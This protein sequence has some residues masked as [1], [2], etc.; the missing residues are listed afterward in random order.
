MGP[1]QPRGWHSLGYLPHFDSPETIQF[2]TF[3]L[4][5]SLPASATESI[6]LRDHI[7]Q[8]LDRE[9][10]VGLGACWLKR[11]DIASLVEKAL[12]HFDGERYRL[13]AW[14]LM[15]NHVHV[16]IEMIDGHS[17]SEVVGSWKSFTA[18]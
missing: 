12:L 15:P 7:L 16:V 14:C 1:M 10:D 8:R 2:V 3:R 11:P 5:D 6:R 13:L 4:A 9:L 17:L 18:K